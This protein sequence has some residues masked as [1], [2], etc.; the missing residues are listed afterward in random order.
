MRVSF[1]RTGD[2]KITLV[3]GA[4]RYTRLVRVLVARAFIEQEDEHF[5]TVILLDNDQSNLSSTNLMWRPRKYAWEYAAQFNGP[6]PF[7][8]PRPV[9]DVNTGRI[10]RTVKE[11]AITL[12]VLAFDIYNSAQYGKQTKVTGHSFQWLR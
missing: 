6:F 2:A 5:N 3:G 10:F 9:Q 7:D 8:L 11:A 1:T 12:G 4:D